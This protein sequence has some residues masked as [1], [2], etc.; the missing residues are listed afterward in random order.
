MK[1]KINHFNLV[2]LGLVA[3]ASAMANPINIT[4]SGSPPFTG[5]TQIT[6]NFTSPSNLGDPTVFDWL[7]ADVSAYDSTY[8]ASYPAPTGDANNKPLFKDDSIP[9]NTDSLAITLGTYDYI[10]LHWGGSHGGSV[11]A[12]YIGGETGTF[13]FD[14]SLIGTGNA[15]GGLSSYSFYGPETK[16]VPDFGSTALMLGAALS[17]LGLMTR[18]LKK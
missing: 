4:M 7:K 2:L 12:F 15:V 17:G 10:F 5:S 6:A 14:N 18:R 1:M 11:Q 9:A 3:G 8:S 16:S 13:T